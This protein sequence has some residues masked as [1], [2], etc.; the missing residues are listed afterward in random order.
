MMSTLA[1]T[2]SPIM[3]G[4]VLRAISS[5][6]LISLALWPVQSHANDVGNAAPS[7]QWGDPLPQRAAASA[8]PAW[9]T[10]QLAVNN[11]T[12]TPSA[13]AAPAAATDIE[14]ISD[15]PGWRDTVL[16]WRQKMAALKAF[17]MPTPAE[18]ATDV[19]S[20]VLDLALPSRGVQQAV[21]RARGHSASALENGLPQR[22]GNERTARIH[23]LPT[24]LEL[25]AAL[26]LGQDGKST[27]GKPMSL[28]DAMERGVSNSLDV[29]ASLFRRESFDQTALAARG[30]LLPHL[31]ARGSSGRGELESGNPPARL[32]R[33]EASM[34][35]RQ[36]LFDPAA[37]AEYQ[38]QGVLAV[39][40]DLQYQGA[41]SSASLEVSS[42]YLQALQSRLT[43]ELSRDYEVL[44]G[45]LLTYI[46]ERAN[47]GG[48][49]TAERDRVKARV[50]N[51]RSQMADARANLRAALRNLQ[52]LIKDEPAGLAVMLPAVLA[53]PDNADQARQEA[54]ESN[55]D[56]IVAR[57]EAEAA[58]LEIKTN[59]GKYLPRIDF[60]ISHNRSLNGAGTVSYTQDTKAAVVANWSLING[61]TD[62]AQARAATARMQEKQLRAD[63]V[64]RKLDTEVEAAYAALDAVNERYAALR[65]ELLAN[66][67]VVDAFKAQL[68]GGNRPLLDVLDAYQRLHQS[69]TDLAQLMISEVQ[70]HVKVA[71]LTGRL[72]PIA[73]A[74]AAAAAN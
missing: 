4:H 10:A 37:R 57:T 74:A 58:A 60:E 8:Q 67:T 66:R 54:H 12:S 6:C 9:I 13:G 70:N 36:P 11:S 28:A 16:A 3:S 71:H 32:K 1:F 51:A 34:T 55:R 72:V 33:K 63:D 22:A 29:K 38:R 26:S 18:M 61:G 47:A 64:Q 40:S 65:E 42:A 48:T 50:A 59:T 49:S 43:I 7:P 17:K 25:P 23:E 39:S 69:K 44:L 62:I 20:T 45:E 68:V 19:W 27:V 46:T 53:I 21:S 35:F 5:A 41:V 56:L 2:L 73:S 52:S 24:L 30:A 31:D 15:F 14:Q